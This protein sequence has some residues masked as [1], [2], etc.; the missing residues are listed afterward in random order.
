MD[1]GCDNINASWTDNLNKQKD[2][3]AKAILESQYFDL[4]I[5]KKLLN[6]QKGM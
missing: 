3:L 6:M 5:N 2:K 4:E 1:T